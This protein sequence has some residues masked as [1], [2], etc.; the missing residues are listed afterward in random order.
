MSSV[1]LLSDDVRVALRERRAVV[2]LETSVLA[3]GLPA[4]RNLEAAVDLDL[5]V[6]AEGAVPA[7]IAV[8]HGTIRVGLSRGMLEAISAPGARV[9]K[10][11]RRD[12]PAVL[13]GGGMGA[14]TVSATLW[15]AA[16]LGI[17]VMATGGIGGVHPHTGD[18]SA[19][20]LEIAR[21]PGLVV[22]AGPKSIVDPAATLERLEELGVLVVGYGCDRLPF[23]LARDAGLPLE[24]RVD[25]PAGAARLARARLQLGVESAVL[26]CNPIH[27]DHALDPAVV[28]RAV[29]EC[30]RR[31]ATG[32]VTGKA[33][34][35]F[36][37]SCLAEVTGGASLE[38]NVALLRANAVLAAQ[39]AVEL[40]RG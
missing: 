39:V 20:L 23:F 35:P 14:T 36:L 6:R 7:W 22:C 31:A 1:F 10:V 34:T 24:H 4:P 40:A 13:A 38:S 21:V 11:A 26:L 17:E 32:G 16:A 30:E 27:P 2:A 3:Q 25:T 19:D 12:Y 15:V 9:A 8:D 37:L 33:V 5:R 28:A 29:E 18:V